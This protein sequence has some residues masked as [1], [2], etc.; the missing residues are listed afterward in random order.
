MGTS[1]ITLLERIAITLTI[2]STSLGIADPSPVSDVLTLL[3]GFTLSL[4]ARNR[5]P[6]TIKSYTGSVELFRSYLVSHG[7]PTAVDNINREHVEAFIADQLQRWRPK[8]AQVRYGDLRQFFKWCVEEGEIGVH[9][10]AQMKP[11]T[12]PDVPVPVVGDD[13]IRK[14]LKVC[15]GRDFDDRRDTALLR[16]FYDSG[17]RLGEVAALG[18]DDVDLEMQ[19]VVVLGKGRKPRSVPFGD[20]TAQAMERYLRM[21]S[22]HTRASAPA[23]WLGPRGPLSD[24]GIAQMLRRRCRQANIEQLHPHQLRHTAVHTFL[25]SGGSEGDAMRLYGWRS[26]QMLG[27]YAA[28]TADERARESFRRLSPGDRL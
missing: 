14:L 27:R 4:R 2:V 11:P 13:D 1:R 16:L 24:S 28:S 8:T 9:P 7:M 17:P 6:K 25:A 20:K 5:S 22:R 12:V 15:D 3:P 18:I 10:M 19:V 21:R 23:L 26:R